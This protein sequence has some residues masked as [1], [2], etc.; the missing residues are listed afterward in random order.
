MSAKT[1]TSAHSPPSRDVDRLHDVEDFTDKSL[2]A[3]IGRIERSHAPEH[4][5][6]REA[7]L[8]EVWRLVEGALRDLRAQGGSGE[9]A[10]IMERLRAIVMRAHEFVGVDA[11]V[12]KAAAEL[13]SGIFLALSCVNL[14]RR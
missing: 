8:D 7:E 12:A 10:A 5:V 1:G 4:M 14:K 11:D 6:Y 3:L 13:R 2:R 9:I